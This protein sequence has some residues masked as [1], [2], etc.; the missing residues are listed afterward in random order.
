MKKQLS[1]Q[2]PR[3]TEAAGTG[4]FRARVPYTDVLA[5]R[6]IERI[7]AF[8]GYC[9]GS[10]FPPNNVLSWVYGGEERSSSG[11]H[12]LSQRAPARRNPNGP[13]FEQSS[14]CNFVKWG[15]G[16][17]ALNAVETR[18]ADERMLA[19]LLR[20][21]VPALAHQPPGWKANADDDD[22][23]PRPVH[24][25]PCS[26]SSSKRPARRQEIPPWGTRQT[27][28][29]VHAWGRVVGGVSWKANA[30]PHFIT[31]HRAL[32]RVTGLVANP[33]P[34]APA[35][36]LPGF[37]FGVSGRWRALSKGAV[38][39]GLLQNPQS[40]LQITIIRITSDRPGFPFGFLWSSARPGACTWRRGR[41][42]L[43]RGAERNERT[44][45]NS[46]A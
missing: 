37:P 1:L 28:L 25:V 15:S 2:Q 39:A 22:T 34:R 41:Q 30:G 43:P 35:N 36:G 21:E 33:P 32:Q 16:L 8:I 26:R 45:Q 5:P 29:G 20:P 9:D 14:V 46:A 38:W 4:A 13:R 10:A 11:F 3:E 18:R 6:A 17:E 42:A 7:F 19:H 31:L 40:S 27:V 23:T 12:R 44:S 24:A